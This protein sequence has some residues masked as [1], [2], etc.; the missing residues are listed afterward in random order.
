DTSD[1]RRVRLAAR[2]KG[3]CG[4]A[5]FYR[6]GMQR[7]DRQALLQRLIGELAHPGPDGQGAHPDG[8]AGLA[9]ARLRLIDAAA[10]KQPM[11]NE[12]ATVWISFNGEIF[13]YVELR[14]ELLARGHIFKTS[15]DTEVI[16]HLYEERGPDCVETL[17]GDFAFAIWDLNKQRMM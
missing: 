13:N 5:G 9:D 1:R 15:S 14:E 16:V 11:C 6:L 3:M 17:N 10:G 7:E 12:D 8:E 4:I 2:T